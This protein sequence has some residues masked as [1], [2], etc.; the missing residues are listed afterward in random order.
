MREDEDD[1]DI[2]LRLLLVLEGGDSIQDLLGCLLQTD[3][4]HLPGSG[5]GV[6][7]GGEGVDLGD[8]EPG[9][10]GEHKIKQ[11][12]AHVDHDVVILEDT[13]LDGLTV[14]SPPVAQSAQE[15]GGGGKRL[16][17]PLGVPVVNVSVYPGLVSDPGSLGDDGGLVIA[18]LGG[19]DGDE[20]KTEEELEHDDV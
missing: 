6:H 5:G 19:G 18:G 3:G 15:R 17:D 2:L 14:P 11:V 10:G 1:D 8:S 20:K 12:L 4:P 13:L 9:Q 16:G 7:G